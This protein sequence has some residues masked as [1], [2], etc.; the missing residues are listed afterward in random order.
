[1]SSRTARAIKRNPVSR[2]KK[3]KKKNRTSDHLEVELQVVVNHMIWILG[4]ELW[5]SGNTSRALYH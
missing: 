5:F 1:V 4:T 2:K 3:K